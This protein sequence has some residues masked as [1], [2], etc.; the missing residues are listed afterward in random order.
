MKSL[1]CA[2]DVD[3][4]S[5]WLLPDMFIQEGQHSA[6]CC[7]NQCI[8]QPRIIEHMPPVGLGYKFVGDVMSFKGFGHQNRLLEGYVGILLTME[9]QGWR[10]SLAQP[11]G[12]A[13][14]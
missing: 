14:T 3:E 10:N 5:Q 8:F 12:A 4:A 11:H 2:I 1:L 6:K 9:Q 13:L 7:L